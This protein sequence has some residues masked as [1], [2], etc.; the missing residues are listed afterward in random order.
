[1]TNDSDVQQMGY[2]A[3]MLYV[4]DPLA[5]YHIVVKD[6]QDYDL[7]PEFRACATSH[8]TVAESIEMDVP[9]GRTMS[10]LALLLRGYKV[11]SLTSTLVL[12][13]RVLTLLRRQSHKT[14]ETA[15]SD[16]LY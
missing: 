14:S 10:L 8:A 9:T 15:K 1:M 11:C 16:L 3:E 6:Q 13:P 5:L 7:T 2:K 4:T 12:S